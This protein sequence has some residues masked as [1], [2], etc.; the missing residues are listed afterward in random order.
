MFT[1]TQE[2]LGQQVLEQLQQ[3][4]VILFGVG[5]VGGWCAESLIRTGV[6]HLTL[7]DFDQIALSNLNRQL[8][9]TYDAIGLPKVEQMRQRLLS[10]NPNAD[11]QTICQRYDEDS[12]SQYVFDH[13]DYVIDAIDTL[14]AKALLIHQ[15]TCSSATLF[16]S[17]GAGRKLDA[18]RIR[19]TEFWKVSGCPLARALRN[20]MRK[21]GHMPQK[22]FQCVYSDEIS[23]ESGT[24][25]PIVGVFGMYLSHLLIQD[26]IRKANEQE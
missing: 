18:T 7:V 17:M 10:I 4:R 12:A 1:R 20:K 23:S 11:I 6:Q 9:A 19:T 21:S 14:D 13:Y 24:I 8:V 16:S 26:I 5:G 22:K 2:I 25:A 15:A 3:V